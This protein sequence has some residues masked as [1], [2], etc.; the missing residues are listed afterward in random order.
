MQETIGITLASAYTAS[1][2]IEAT[3]KTWE[4]H[5]GRWT[6][7]ERLPEKVEKWTAKRRAARFKKLFEFD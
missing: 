7:S 6:M 3:N 5:V 4:N 1:L 2:V